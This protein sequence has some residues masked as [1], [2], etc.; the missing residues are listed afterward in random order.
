MARSDIQNVEL[1]N[2]EENQ[3]YGLFAGSIHKIIHTDSVLTYVVK[4]IYTTETLEIP[5]NIGPEETKVWINNSGQLGFGKEEQLFTSF[6]HHTK[7][8]WNKDYTKPIDETILGDKTYWRARK[9]EASLMQLLTCSNSSNPY[10]Q[11]YDFTE[12]KGSDWFTEILEG[13][14]EYLEKKAV[15]SYGVQMKIGGIAYV[16]ET[17]GIFQPFCPPNL[18]PFL[19]KN[20]G[21]LDMVKKDHHI[22]TFLKAIHHGVPGYFEWQKLQ[23]WEDDEIVVRRRRKISDI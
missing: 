4:D 13:D 15:N 2:I 8:V 11:K 9:G 16:A 20:K 21:K 12:G 19:I 1:K 18:I 3:L 14:I 10:N 17:Q 7:V 6:K 5:F 22:K 23:I